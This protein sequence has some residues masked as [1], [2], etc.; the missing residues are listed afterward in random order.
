MFILII[1]MPAFIMSIAYLFHCGY[2]YNINSILSDVDLIINRGFLIPLH[3]FQINN[4]FLIL[5]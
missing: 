1:T 4:Y 3:S 2:K 5:K